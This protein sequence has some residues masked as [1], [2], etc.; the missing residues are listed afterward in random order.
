MI[1]TAWNP[2]RKLWTSEY[3]WEIGT[4]E[5]WWPKP[6]GQVTADLTLIVWISNVYVT[7]HIS[8]KRRRRWTERNQRREAAVDHK[9]NRTLCERIGM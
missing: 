2:R 9:V 1:K 7:Q 4:R 3:M 6:E 8:R 5:N